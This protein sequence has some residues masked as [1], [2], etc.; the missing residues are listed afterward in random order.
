MLG[1]FHLKLFQ[2]NVAHGDE[3]KLSVDN[4]KVQVVIIINL[5]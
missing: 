4:L 1:E 5:S 2:S 3:G